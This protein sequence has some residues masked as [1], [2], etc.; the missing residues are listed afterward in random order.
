MQILRSFGKV[1]KNGKIREK[2]GSGWVLNFFLVFLCVVF[3]FP[4]VSK[5]QL[6][7]WIVGWVG[8]V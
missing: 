5:K 6:K 7:N 3:M 1:E 8:A 2:L 4:N